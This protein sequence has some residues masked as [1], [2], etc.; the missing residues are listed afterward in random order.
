MLPGAVRRSGP[1][2][3]PRRA[4]SRFSPLH[5]AVWRG[6]KR[7]SANGGC[8]LLGIG[9]VAGFEVAAAAAADGAPVARLAEDRAEDA[10][11]VAE[12]VEVALAVDALELVARHLGD[13]HPGAGDP[14]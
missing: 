7:A 9:A 5:P 2:P 1:P 13:L 11:A 6:G 10:E 14:Q 12:G 3:S 4:L 8:R